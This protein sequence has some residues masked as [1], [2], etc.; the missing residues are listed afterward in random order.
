[1]TSF[2]FQLS[3]MKF[4]SFIIS[5]FF[6]IV[7]KFQFLYTT[8]FNQVHFQ[9]Y[10]FNKLTLACSFNSN[11]TLS[12][13][14]TFDAKSICLSWNITAQQRCKRNILLLRY[15]RYRFGLSVRQNNK[16]E[17]TMSTELN[18]WAESKLNQKHLLSFHLALGVWLVFQR[19]L[20]FKA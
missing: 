6:W 8:Y 18:W 16:P 5:S 3:W 20:A 10:Y 11:Y 9:A 7:K 17:D 15:L 2:R 12:D 1:M 13:L 14:S 19:W 4:I